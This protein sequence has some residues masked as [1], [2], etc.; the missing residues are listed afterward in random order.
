MD[1]SGFNLEALMVARSHLFDNG[2]QGSGFFQMVEDHT[3]LRLRTFLSKH[4]YM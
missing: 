3:E 2:D 4:Y 1:A